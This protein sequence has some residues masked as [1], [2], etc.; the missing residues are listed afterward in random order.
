MAMGQGKGVE[1]FTDF[2]TTHNRLVIVLFVVL[3]AGIVFGVTQDAGEAEQGIDEDAMGDTEVGEAAEYI[4]ENYGEDA[5]EGETQVT[6]DVFVKTDEDT[7]LDRKGLLTALDYQLAVSEKPAVADRLADDGISG[8]PN[9]I[10]T[11]LAE[12]PDADLET[13][14]EE[15][16]N[17][18]EDEVA[19]A[20]EATFTGGEATR[21]YLPTTYEAGTTDAEAMRLTFT[22]AEAEETEMGTSAPPDAQEVLYETAGEYDEPAIFTT[23]QFAQADLNQE[24]LMDSLWLVLPP[25]LLVLLIILGFAYR[26]VT[27]V[28]IGFAGSLV[29]LAWTFGLMGWMGLLSQQTGLIVP[30]LIAALSID[31]GFHVFMR[32]RE[33]RGPEDGIRTTLSRSTAAVAV[34]FLLVTVTA[35]IGFLSNLLSPV[36]II[37]DLGIAITL[38]VIS[39]LVIFTTLVPALKVSADGLWERFG[40]DRR[41]TALGKGRYLSRVLGIGATAAERAAVPV[42]VIVLVAG[43]A[44]GLTFTDLDREPFQQGDFDD[45]AEWKENL[46]GPMAFE[47]HESDIAQQYMY[48]QEHFQADQE[49][50]DAEG[51]GTGFTQILIQDEDGVAT[52]ETME[53]VAVS[54]E[55]AQAA[56]DDV[57][58]QHGEEVHVVSPLSMME[59]V[60]AEDEEFAATFEAADS[61][62]DGVPDRNIE[63]L[64]DEFYETAPEQ[65]S[66][67]LERTEDGTYESMLV[68]VPAQGVGSERAEVMH[69]IA[70]EMEAESGLSTTA[71]GI[72]TI[73]DAELTEIAN[74]IVQTMAL[75][76]AGVLLTLM[77]VYRLVHDS[78]ALGAVTVLP[79]ALALGLV[80]A[81]MHLLGQ[82]LTMLTALLVS[83]TIGLGIDYN[84]HVSDR[85][86]Q[87]LE[88]DNDPT[89]A[90]RE[91]VTGTGGALL[92]S[93]VTSG[94]AFALL[95]LIP[96]P[97][98]TSFGIIVALALTVSF[99][100]SVFV[101]PSL[102]YLWS[103]Q[104]DEGLMGAHSRGGGARSD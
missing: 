19:A 15:V 11:A 49:G 80:F 99:L 17:A 84:I 66:Q 23:G 25:I 96:S 39:A 32:Y 24:F 83:V 27:D 26:D 93:A 44:G 54:H 51:G 102:L 28:L 13:Q 46:P 101:L 71:V 59:E 34:A 69:G 91:S 90:L 8:P 21:F 100:L 47:A 75:A 10:A 41:K 29:A 48:A 36:P 4:S 77:V 92:G 104:W 78:A 42:L 30:V 14:R 64:Y 6:V 61:T 63:E 37:Q 97:Q 33:R 79:I 103:T 60:A 57:V 53:A 98:F 87:E 55:A 68:M 73:Q 94:S 31:F 20:V 88:R 74:G 12:D 22:F 86:V 65:A 85:F 43:L 70:D 82:P 50:F 9:M 67:V 1:K 7:V 95:I 18:S 35:A 89:T 3:T 38:G 5:D 62:G 45:V 72:A 58:I 81:G 40:F 16:A 52:A 2:V 56:D 76:L